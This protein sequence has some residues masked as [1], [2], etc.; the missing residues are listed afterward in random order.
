MASS[1]VGMTTPQS[2][3]SQ[4]PHRALMLPDILLQIFSH[5]SKATL[6]RIIRVCRAWFIHGV[7][8]I[9]REVNGGKPWQVLSNIRHCQP[10]LRQDLGGIF[11][12]KPAV[13]DDKHDP[14]IPRARLLYYASKIRRLDDKSW[15]PDPTTW[16]QHAGDSDWFDMLTPAMLAAMNR[17]L[18]VL[19]ISSGIPGPEARKGAALPAPVTG[20]LSD[21]LTTFSLCNTHYGLGNGLVN[22]LIARCPNVTDIT[23]DP[24]PKRQ[25]K[26]AC[27]LLAG[28]PNLVRIT[29]RGAFTP[30]TDAPVLIAAM[31][32]LKHLRDVRFCPTDG[33][34]SGVSSSSVVGGRIPTSTANSCYYK[35]AL[36]DKLVPLPTVTHLRFARAD[37]ALLDEL[38]SERLFPAVRSVMLTVVV[39]CADTNTNTIPLELLPRLGLA[40]LAA[41]WPALRDIE[42]LLDVPHLPQPVAWD[43]TLMVL[44]DWFCGPGDGTTEDRMLQIPM[45]A[46][47]QL[48]AGRAR[49][50]GGHGDGGGGGRL[51]AGRPAPFMPGTDA[52]RVT[53]VVTN[54]LATHESVLFWNEGE[55]DEHDDEE[56]TASLLPSGPRLIPWSEPTGPYRHGVPRRGAGPRFLLHVRAASFA[57]EPPTGLT[58][59]FSLSSRSVFSM[60]R[61]YLR[62]DADVPGP[63]RGSAG[64]SKEEEE[65]EEDETDG[66]PVEGI[67]LGLWMRECMDHHVNVDLV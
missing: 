36:A 43:L 51:A 56:V 64:D 50:G 21:R 58:H 19:A 3:L 30:R 22:A 15:K 5:L 66:G 6:A 16:H 54:G 31:A 17:T 27:R 4:G 29:L 53:S 52:G 57:P 34:K 63:R 11:P 26:L 33:R 25:R 9:W 18:R 23:L 1:T 61:A 48:I 42:V 60:L 65:E 45:D 37:L 13:D 46:M 67:S 20:L 24:H 32:G 10:S 28:L 47:P 35:P 44:S 40:R 8:D 14:P 49:A 38:L 41:R 62:Q 39:D 2:D 55:H 12:P 59:K 7:D